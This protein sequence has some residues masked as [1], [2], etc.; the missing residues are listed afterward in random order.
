MRCCSAADATA[1]CCSCLFSSVLGLLPSN[2]CCSAVPPI[3][4]AAAP[5]H[6]AWGLAA[7]CCCFWTSKSVIGCLERG[8]RLT[9]L[10]ASLVARDS[11]R[12]MPCS[13]AR[14]RCHGPVP[15]NTSISLLLKFPTI[16]AGQPSRGA[17][18]W[19]PQWAVFWRFDFQPHTLGH[20]PKRKLSM[21]G[22]LD[23]S[24]RQ[25]LALRFEW[26]HLGM[27]LLGWPEY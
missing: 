22:G 11:D 6:Q 9:E 1:C 25:P 15:R 10:L 14:G 5:W 7:A 21:Q 26:Q 13:L 17:T 12:P 4:A 2:C 18:S 19:R 23:A 16:A 24:K 8:Y 3:A 20:L 27:N